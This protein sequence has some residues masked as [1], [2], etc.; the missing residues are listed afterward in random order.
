[1]GNEATGEGAAVLILEKARA[2]I[3]LTLDVLG[4]RP[5]G[6]HEVEMLMQTIDLC[7]FLSFR[8]MAGGEIRL[9]CTVSFVPVDERNLVYR[10]A[11]AL[12]DAAGVRRGAAIEIDKRIPVAAGLAGGSADA[13]AALRGLNDLWDLG[14]TLDELAVIGA[15]VGSDVPFCVYGGTAVARGRGERIERLTESASLWVVLAKPAIAVSTA[16]IYSALRIP[17]IARR[18]D[19]PEVL[20]AVRTGNL[21]RLAAATCNVLEPVTS[22][23][24]PEVP[25]VIEQMRRLGSPVVMMSGSGPTVFALFEREQKARRVYTSMRGVLKEVYLCRMC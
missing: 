1:M 24:F 9:H 6:Y 11:L 18:P 25:R 5:D 7:D 19:L 23:L 15:R 16:D 2:K 3:N 8:E 17:E 12:Q 20:A 4:R 14:F 13:A 22:R 10:A 21:D